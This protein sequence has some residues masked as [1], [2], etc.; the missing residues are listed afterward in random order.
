MPEQRLL[1][2][3]DSD[4]ALYFLVKGT[5][6]IDEAKYVHIS[7]SKDGQK[8]SSDVILTTLDPSS[9]TEG[10]QSPCSAR[11]AGGMQDGQS[12]SV[13]ADDSKFICLTD[14]GV[15]VRDL[16]A[17]GVYISSFSGLSML[18]V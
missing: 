12:C 18:F 11:A 9:D 3:I 7:L 16:C 14:G 10:A 13:A 1:G 4:I 8:K 2:D 6:R 17:G 15:L 5:I